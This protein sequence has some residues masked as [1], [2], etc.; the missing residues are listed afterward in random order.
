MAAFDLDQEAILDVLAGQSVV[1]VAFRDGDE[2]Y[3]IPLGYVWL[4]GAMQGVSGPG[5]KTR[6][7]QADPRVTFQVDTSAES[8]WFEWRSVTGDGRFE[9]VTDERQ[10][11]RTLDAWRP[12]IEQAPAWWRREI[13]PAVDAGKLLVWRLTP[14]HASGRRFGRPDEGG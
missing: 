12:T 8:G 3:L 13:E 4:D 7:A 9:I 11:R 14:I 2:R 10:R 6:L 5:R 1:R